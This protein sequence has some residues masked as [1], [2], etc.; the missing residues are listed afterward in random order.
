MKILV[1]KNLARKWRANKFQEII[2]QDLA[3]RIL[4]NSL[5]KI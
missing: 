1:Q 3:V 5:Y 4:K 2:G